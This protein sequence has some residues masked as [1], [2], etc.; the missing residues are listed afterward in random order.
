MVET[1]ASF[2]FDPIV[3]KWTH[4]QLLRLSLSPPLCTGRSPSSSTRPVLPITTIARGPGLR[5][6]PGSRLASLMMTVTSSCR[7]RHRPSPSQKPPRPILGGNGSKSIVSI[8]R[9]SRPTRSD[10]FSVNFGRRRREHCEREVGIAKRELELTRRE[11]S[12]LREE[13]GLER[14][15]RAL[16]AEVEEA[17]KRGA[18]TA[19]C[20]GA[21]RGRSRRAWSASSTQPRRSSVGYV[22]ISR[23]RTTICASCARRRQR[24]KQQLRQQAR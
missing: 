12:V 22:W 19:R 3:A 24:L 13:V 9:A 23:S 1:G 2:E 18:E 21:P 4:L 16:R 10:K 15:L 17:R 8:V 20:R 7:R 5:V 14:G 11:L 6:K